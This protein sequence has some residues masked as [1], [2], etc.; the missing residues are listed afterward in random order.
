MNR[1][2]GMAPS[3]FE[4]YQKACGAA[5]INPNRVSQ[6]IGDAPASN[7]FHAQDGTVLYNGKQV[8]YCASVDLGDNGLTHKQI[9]GWLVALA[10]RDIYGWFRDWENNTHLH[11]VDSALE[12]KEGLFLQGVDYL[13]DRN[14]LKG[15]A[16]E[17]FYT[18]PPEYDRSI[19]RELKRSN[20]KFWAK[21]ENRIP[22]H[23]RN[24]EPPR[25]FVNGKQ[26][27]EAYLSN[28]TW[29]CQ[30]GAL[31]VILGG[32]TQTEALIAPVMALANR[33]GW[34]KDG[35]DGYNQRLATMNR[36]DLRLVKA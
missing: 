31:A 11:V 8:P 30:E 1:P 9:K 33:W 13:N 36:A 20:P 7:G 32:T 12:M 26:V 2:Y 19:A 24:D 10:A 18:A 23:Y 35:E 5:N 28:G 3:T 15:H 6:T 4:K 29:Y 16:K 27:K 22:K 25:L 14:G 17:T 21:Y 34:V